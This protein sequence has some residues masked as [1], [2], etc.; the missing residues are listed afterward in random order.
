M[1]GVIKLGDTETHENSSSVFQV[2]W[3]TPVSA[4]WVMHTHHHH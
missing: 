1:G 3:L 4:L 2:T